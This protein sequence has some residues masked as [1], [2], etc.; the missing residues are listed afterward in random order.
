MISNSVCTRCKFLEP[1][2]KNYA[3]KNGFSFEEKDISQATEIEIGDSTSLPI[4]WLWD[5]KLT[6]DEALSLITN[7]NG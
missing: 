3:E 7:T 1:H 4:I 6:Y 2:L 5:K